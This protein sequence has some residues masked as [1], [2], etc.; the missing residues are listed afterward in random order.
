ML[1][2]IISYSFAISF[3]EDVHLVEHVTS[4]LFSYFTVKHVLVYPESLGYCGVV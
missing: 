3:F 4:Q 2:I 1:S